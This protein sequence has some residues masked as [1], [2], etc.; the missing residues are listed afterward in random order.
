MGKWA[1][2]RCHCPNRIALPKSG[3]SDRPFARRRHLTAAQQREV[4]VWERDTKLMYECGHREGMLFQGWPGKILELCEAIRLVFIDEPDTFEICMR[5]G[6]WRSACSASMEETMTLSAEEAEL[7]QLEAQELIASLELKGSVSFAKLR[8]LISVMWRF[9]IAAE[10]NVQRGLEQT[11]LGGYSSLALMKSG[12]EE[13]P[14]SNEKI[15]EI[16]LLA[17]EDINKFC[18]ASIASGKP[19]EFYF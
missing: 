17:L 1:Q 2:V 4:E 12:S 10:M 16:C 6:A 18:A 14:D 15:V 5:L 11:W 8:S 7:W 9:E 13:F 3:L 19:I